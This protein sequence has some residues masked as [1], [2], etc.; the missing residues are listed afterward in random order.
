MLTPSTMRWSTAK[1][2]PELEE[3]YRK[4]NRE[5]ARGYRADNPERAKRQ[6]RKDHDRLMSDP[7]RLE[8]KRAYARKRQKEYRENNLR[9][10]KS[11]RLKSQYGITLEEYEEMYGDQNG[12]CALCGKPET[13][14]YR[15]KTRKLAVDHCHGTGKVRALLCSN[16]N[17]GLGS[18]MHDP[19]LLQRAIS[20]LDRYR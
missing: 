17:T 20:Y 8:K 6:H 3:E 5:H 13:S 14:T 1:G 10:W 9:A 2:N 4:Y 15:G 19:E 7:E 11:G 12:L 16:C 18:F